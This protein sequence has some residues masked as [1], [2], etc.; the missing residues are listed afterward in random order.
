M[1]TLNGS[2]FGM[3]AGAAIHFD[4]PITEHFSAHVGV[5]GLTVSRKDSMSSTSWFGAHAG[6][7]MHVRKAWLDAHINYG[8][9]GAVKRHG[10]DVGVGYDFDVGEK[11]QVG[12]SLRYQMGS[13][14]L[15]QHAQIV[16]VGVAFSYADRKRDMGVLIA[17]SDDD[18]IDDDDDICPKVHKGKN[19]DPGRTGCPYLDF[20]GDEVADADDVCPK[21]HMGPNPDPERDGC[22]ERDRDNDMVADREDACPDEA[23]APSD[24]EERN[25][26][27]GL[28]LVKDAQIRINRPIFFDYDSARIKPESYEVLDAVLAAM[29]KLGVKRLRIEGHTDDNGGDAYNEELSLR[30]AEAVEQWLID[31]E[32]G[33]D[34][35]TVRGYGKTRP[36][37]TED[38]SKNR[39]V[40]F[41]ILDRKFKKAKRRSKKRRAKRS[42]RRRNSDDV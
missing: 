12:P 20:D 38:D 13:D 27:P 15:N 40:E 9:S 18:G 19:P 31:N 35:L 16:T 37:S 26:C 11:Y 32:V 3:A 6:T 25:G 34:A 29:N 36:L 28:V 41:H 14:P 10:F 21:M 1:D 7:R 4:R 23:G 22:P 2:L 33:L 17:D 8:V 5:K 24:D 39:R 42:K 30:R